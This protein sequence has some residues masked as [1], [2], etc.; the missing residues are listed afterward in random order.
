M[1]TNL[2]SVFP[3]KQLANCGVWT[4]IPGGTGIKIKLAFSGAAN[5]QWK[6]QSLVM[7]A[8]L[9]TVNQQNP[10]EIDL[11][12]LN[13]EQFANLESENRKILSQTVIKSWKGLKDEHGKAV[14]CTP[15]N[16][17]KLMENHPDFQLF[18][19]NFS[20][21]KANFMLSKED[22]AEDIKKK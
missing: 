13:A 20:G 1:K 12:K 2:D 6:A 17:E 5:Q 3:S 11:S 15:K 10:A 22:P 21:N 7:A 4:E 16:A 14:L 18:I 19:S 8:R 9:G